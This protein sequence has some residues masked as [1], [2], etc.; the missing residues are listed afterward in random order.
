VRAAGKTVLCIGDGELLYTCVHTFSK[1]G[2]LFDGLM[3]NSQDLSVPTGANDVSMIQAAQIGCGISGREGR[4]AVLA[5]D[6]AFAQFRCCAYIRFMTR[7][8]ATCAAAGSTGWVTAC[9]RFITRLLLVHGRWSH[10]RNAEIVQ[11]TF[12]KNLVCVCVCAY[13]DYN[14]TRTFSHFL[15]V[16]QSKIGRLQCKATRL[17][18]P[19]L[20]NTG[21]LAAECLLR[22]RF[23]CG[24]LSTA[25]TYTV[26]A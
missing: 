1:H 12:Y 24:R 18:R 15:F 6:Y 17:L 25:D 22:V 5:S 19:L 14:K 23:W 9:R 11:Y 4:A 26:Q 10:K 21:V 2:D 8:S 13:T 3:N 16:S 7:R 20:C